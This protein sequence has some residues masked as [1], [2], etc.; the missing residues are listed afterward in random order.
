MNMLRYSSS[1]RKTTCND[2]FSR[3]YSKVADSVQQNMAMPPGGDLDQIGMLNRCG[4]L[5]A[6]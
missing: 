6:E 3:V 2:F 5:K 1:S 4:E